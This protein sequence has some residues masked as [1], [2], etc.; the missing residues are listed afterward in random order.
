MAGAT[1]EG[2]SYLVEIQ[3]LDQTAKEQALVSKR[4]N[5]SKFWDSRKKHAALH[6]RIA[7]I[8]QSKSLAAYQVAP[9]VR[10]F[11]P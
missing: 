11:I 8:S 5:L 10:V 9:G 6:R 1:K 7:D 4:A 3:L 2:A